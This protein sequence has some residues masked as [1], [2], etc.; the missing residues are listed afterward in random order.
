MKMKKTLF[1]IYLSIFLISIAFVNAGPMRNI[2]IHVEDVFINQNVANAAVYMYSDPLQYYEFQGITDENGNITFEVD[3]RAYVHINNSI[4]STESTG[5][6]STAKNTAEN[7]R[8]DR[9]PSDYNPYKNK[10]FHFEIT[11]TGSSINF[12]DFYENHTFKLNQDK[13]FNFNVT[14]YFNVSNIPDYVINEADNHQMIFD[15]NDYIVTS[16][17]ENINFAF[18]YEFSSIDAYFNFDEETWILTVDFMPEMNLD[19]HINNQIQIESFF[20]LGQEVN[21]QVFFVNYIPSHKAMMGH[22]Q[23]H[24]TR[25]PIYN[26][27]INST[28]HVGELMFSDNHETF[29]GFYF[30]GSDGDPI[31]IQKQGYLFSER[32]IRTPNVEQNLSFTLIPELIN[33]STLHNDLFTQLFRWENS[34]TV[35]QAEYS[36]DLNTYSICTAGFDG[37]NIS[38]IELSRVNF[39]LSQVAEF[40][41]NFHKPFEGYIEYINNQA[42]CL[43]GE[44][45]MGY[46]SIIWNGSM[47]PNESVIEY[48]YWSNK[49]Y[50][51]IIRL[52]GN[53]Q[54]MITQK[55]IQAI[56]TPN[57][58][59]DLPDSVFSPNGAN[60]T[61]IDDINFGRRLYMRR[62]RNLA[63]D[64]DYELTDRESRY[65]D[66]KLTTANYNGGTSKIETKVIDHAKN[67][68]ELKNTYLTKPKKAKKTLSGRILSKKVIDKILMLFQ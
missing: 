19:Y 22:I 24:Y 11:P 60:E 57:I 56:S 32:F 14:N 50:G 17:P 26:S 1:I 62:P 66:V 27:S 61:S 42:D 30:Y 55:V 33:G 40:T 23:D 47:G 38:N 8:E 58:Q 16:E 7:T 54:S 18:D 64:V 36:E 21:E 9:N 35:R 31:Y 13:N 43:I 6:L 68:Q 39:S 25:E 4:P 3:A 51:A 67:K 46:I 34:G 44:P 52:G 12:G 59:Y 29:L 37:Y 15:L 63:P 5:G 48:L 41:N 49:I 65:H 10:T 20:T 45:E 28:T 53:S 2:T